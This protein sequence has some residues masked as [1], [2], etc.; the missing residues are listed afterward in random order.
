ME[1]INMDTKFVG[2][3][4]DYKIAQNDKL[5]IFT[6]FELR[7]K[8]DLSE[9]ETEEFLELA[10]NKLTNTGYRVYY[11]GQSYVYDSDVKKVQDN[12]L[13]VAIKED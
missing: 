4:I 11:T 8:S 12:E 7:L 13:M 9:E 5:I 6:F 10:K 3:Y 1:V 2:E